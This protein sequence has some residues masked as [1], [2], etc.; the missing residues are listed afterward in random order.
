M[1]G[2]GEG[3]GEAVGDGW[4]EPPTILWG[5]PSTTSPLWSPFTFS[6]GAVLLCS[7]FSGLE[8]VEEEDDDDEDEEEVVEEDSVQVGNLTGVSSAAKETLKE[9]KKTS[10]ENHCFLLYKLQQEH[11]LFKCLMDPFFWLLVRLHKTQ[12]S[13]N[14]LLLY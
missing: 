2:L 12:F 6:D 14:G 5:S 13:K 10:R 11:Y 9:N 7:V 8:S 1:V 4:W 3:Q